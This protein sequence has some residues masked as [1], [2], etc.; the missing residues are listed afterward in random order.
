LIVEIEWYAINTGVLW[1]FCATC[2]D[3]YWI[4]W[5]RAPQAQLNL[6]APEQTGDLGE[7]WRGRADGSASAR[8]VDIWIKLPLDTAS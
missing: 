3:V 8:D 1:G 7:R 6:S 4:T 2:V 5:K